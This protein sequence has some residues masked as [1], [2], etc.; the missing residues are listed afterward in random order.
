MDYNFDINNI[1]DDYFETPGP[2]NNLLN[3]IASTHNKPSLYLFSSNFYFSITKENNNPDTDELCKPCL[4]KMLLCIKCQGY[5]SINL[6]EAH[7]QKCS[8]SENLIENNLN[9]SSAEFTLNQNSSQIPINIINNNITS[10]NTNGII[11]CEYCHKKLKPE[12]ADSH[13][14]WCLEKQKVITLDEKKKSLINKFSSYK[15]SLKDYYSQKYPL[16]QHNNPNNPNYSNTQINPF[17]NYNSYNPNIIYPHIPD[18]LLNY[19]PLTNNDYI[20]NNPLSFPNNNNSLFSNNNTLAYPNT[21]NN[22]LFPKQINKI[23]N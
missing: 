14:I 9:K 18:S 10:N 6:F 15:S 16:N 12:W 19:K 21:N 20:Y 23:I 1:D 7:I 4:N 5:F 13:E 8:F 17:I 3:N 22:L 11:E 2:S